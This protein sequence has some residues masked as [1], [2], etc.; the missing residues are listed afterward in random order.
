[1]YGSQSG[2]VPQVLQPIVHP[3]SQSSQGETEHD[4]GCDEFED[5]DGMHAGKT[6]SAHDRGEREHANDQWENDV[7]PRRTAIRHSST[8]SRAQRYRFICRLFTEYPLDL[9]QVVEVV[10]GEH[11]DSVFNG[12][13]A[14]L[15]VHSVMFPLRGGQ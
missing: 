7:S 4:A 6:R 15:G 5:V 11:A 12:F 9:L 8:W 10:A 3:H 1:M 13:L 14:A 2:F